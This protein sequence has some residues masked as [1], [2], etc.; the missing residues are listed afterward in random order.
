MCSVLDFMNKFLSLNSKIY[1]KSAGQSLVEIL[2]AISVGAIL[3]GGATT[4]IISILR[5]NLETRN[6]QIATSLAQEYLDNVQSLAES[7]WHIIY[8][9]PSDK[10]PDSQFYLTASGTSFAILA[11]ATSTVAEG[12]TF[13]RY[14]S[15]EN[16]NR[17]LC[18][19]GDISA[20]ATST[21]TS[22]PG[23]TGT[24]DDPS[25]QKITITI[26]WPENRSI[27]RTQYL[28]RNINKVFAQ[29]DWS[30]GPG[31]T[32]PIT[33]VNNMFASSTDLDYST[34]TG[35]IVIQGF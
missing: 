25:T 9:L 11:G 31:Q 20:A 5:S 16:T 18:G 12:R 2:I 22:G 13:T 30:G 23:S 34:S 17:D 35:S 24:A 8:A 4:V 33:S 1:K 29:T 26:S 3:I 10:G 14:F 27:S 19:A 21:C 7:D 15:I 28:T 32:G 6:V